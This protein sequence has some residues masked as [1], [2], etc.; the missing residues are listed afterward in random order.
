MADEQTFSLL[1]IAGIGLVLPIAAYHRLKA[2]TG[3]PLDRRR[4][5]VF[6][7]STLR[8]AALAYFVGLITYLASPP[9]MAWASLPLPE[10]ARW[11]AAALFPLAAALLLWALRN[12]GTNLTDTVVTRRAHTLVSSGPYRWV[13]H[14]FYDAVALFLAAC[15]LVAANGFLLFCGA[16]VVTL[17]VVRTRIEEA[18][19]AA[20]FGDA[21]RSYVDR[22]GR[23]LP[24]LGA[25]GA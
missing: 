24:R 3:E 18:H 9:R 6:I 12:L 5:G 2:R 7:L 17:L 15:A 4:E 19:L 8:P 10:W 21:Y 20:R 13:R 11:T 16:I 25:P 23:F 1:V 22:T 14:P